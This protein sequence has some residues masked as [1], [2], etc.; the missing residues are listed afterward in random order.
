ML[1]MVPDRGFFG[2]PRVLSMLKLLGRA[3][4]VVSRCDEGQKG[5]RPSLVLS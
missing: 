1:I 2:S 5:S 3:H 4:E